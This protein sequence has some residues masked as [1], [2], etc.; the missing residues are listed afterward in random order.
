MTFQI[1][2]V[3]ALIVLTLNIV[4]NRLFKNDGVKYSQNFEEDEIAGTLS[5]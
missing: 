1:Y 2:S 3:I 5:K 4:I